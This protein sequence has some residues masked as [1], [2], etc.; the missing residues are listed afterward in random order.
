MKKGRGTMD[1]KDLKKEYIDSIMAKLAYT[2]NKLEREK[3]V[4]VSL[5][6]I[7]E[8]KPLVTK[9]DIKLLNEKLL[10]TKGKTIG[11]RLDEIMAKPPENYII[12]SIDFDKGSMEW[13]FKEKGKENEDNNKD[14]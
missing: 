5:D 2:A 8:K 12:Y 14:T 10:V 13:Q 11:N 1:N 6:G 7:Y 3:I 9:E 4:K